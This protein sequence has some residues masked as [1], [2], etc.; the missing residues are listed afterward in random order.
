MCSFSPA[1][2][3]FSVSCT[4]CGLKSCSMVVVTP[5]E[6]VALRQTSN[7]LLPA[8]A[9]NCLAGRAVAEVP[10]VRQRTAVRVGTGTAVER[11]VQRRVTGRG[12]TRG[13]PGHRT[14]RGVG[15]ERRGRRAG[16]RDH[17]VDR[18]GAQVGV[19]ERLL[20]GV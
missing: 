17:L 18:V 15:G 14:G 3:L 5:C 13:T 11:D 19:V 1:G 9:A 12:R 4:R 8:M 10:V 6:S 16:T 2:S 20:A 7:R